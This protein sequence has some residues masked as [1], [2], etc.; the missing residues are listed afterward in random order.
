MRVVGMAASQASAAA[1]MRARWRSVTDQAASSSR[2]RALTS[3]KTRAAAPPR[4]DV[5]LADRVSKRRARMRKPLAMRAAARLSAERPMRNATDALRARA[6][7][8]RTERL[9]AARHASCHRLRERERALVD[10]APRPAGDGGDL[11]DGLFQRDARQ[12]LAQQGV[13][14]ARSLAAAAGGGAITSTISPRGS[15]AGVVVRQRLEIAAPHLLVQL[16]ELAAD[17][18][19]ARAEPGREVGER[20]G[21]PRP[22]LEQHQRRRN[23]ASSA[24][25]VRRAAVLRRQEAVEEEAV[26]RQAGDGERRQQRRGAGQRRSPRGR[27]RA[28]RAPA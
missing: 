1:T 19:L 21:K 7:V 5:D 25:R 14:V 4:H 20:R 11:A 13:D 24:M 10:L 27:P 28:R 26:G 2:S 6:A 17:R 9:S 15:P 8:G 16:G 18:G 3:T 12:R 23:A 22:G